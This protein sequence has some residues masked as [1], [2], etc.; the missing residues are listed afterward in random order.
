MKHSFRTRVKVGKAKRNVH[1]I[2]N[3]QQNDMAQP[4]VFFWGGGEEKKKKQ[5]LCETLFQES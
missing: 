3:C 5:H 1:D 4:V 2:L